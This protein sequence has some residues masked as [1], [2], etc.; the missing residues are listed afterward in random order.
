MDSGVLVLVQAFVMA[1]PAAWLSLG[2][3]DNIFHPSINRDE[4]ARVLALEALEDWPE[5]RAEVGHRA[6]TDAGA[7]RI[8]FALAV[9]AECVASLLLWAGAACLT[10]AFFGA[11][12]RE[13]ARD[14]ALVGAVAFTGVWASFLIGGQWFCYWYG[15]F[16]HPTHMKALVWGLATLIAVAA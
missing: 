11:V 6:V 4:V 8:V 1:L 10:L 9:F 16:G 7:V 5:V 3:L 13:T 14:V 15:A 2:A 12:D